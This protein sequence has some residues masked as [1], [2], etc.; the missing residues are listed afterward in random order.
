MTLFTFHQFY[1]L[2]KLHSIY[3]WSLVTIGYRW[4]IGCYQSSLT[5]WWLLNWIKWNISCYSICCP[6]T[7]NG[8]IAVQKESAR[9][10]IKLKTSQP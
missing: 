2:L 4:S 8:L 10:S 5:I 6:L 3:R 9:N 7:V 1:E